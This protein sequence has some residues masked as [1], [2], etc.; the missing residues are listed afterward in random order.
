MWSMAETVAYYALHYGTPEAP[1]PMPEWPAGYYEGLLDNW[2]RRATVDYHARVAG[3][4][5]PSWHPGSS[6]TP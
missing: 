3:R 1:A 2:F 4:M 5:H 6:S